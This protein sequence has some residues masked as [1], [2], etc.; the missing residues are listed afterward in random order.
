MKALLVILFF[1]GLKYDGHE[2]N[3]AF[4]CSF[5]FLAIFV[6]LTASDL[7]YRF[8]T[9]PAKID[10]SEI[11]QSGEPVDVKKLAR[12]TPELV[13]K[14]QQIFSQQCITCHGAGGHGDGPA[15]AA[16]NPKPRNFTSADGWKNGRAVSQIFGTITTGL[17]GTPMPPFSGLAPAD[18]FALV[19]YVRSLT[20]NPPEDKPDAL[21]ALQTQLGGPAKPRISIEHAMNRMAGEW[22]SA[23]PKR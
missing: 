18:R 7:L 9:E 8:D 1:M 16:L 4:F 10:T 5:V 13:M 23:H 20:P 19:H 6:G 12:A 17:P 3:V 2:N 15:A 11:V 14:G 22:E 21:A